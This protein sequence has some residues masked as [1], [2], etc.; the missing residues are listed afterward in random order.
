MKRLG[1]FMEY[2]QLRAN[3]F[4]VM[5]VVMVSLAFGI[6][7]FTYVPIDIM[8]ALMGLMFLIFLLVEIPKLG[9]YATLLLLP[10]FWSPFLDAQLLGISGIKISV[11]LPLIAFLYL[12]F[13][14]KPRKIQGEDQVFFLIFI[15][16]FTVS[17]VRSFSYL[18]VRSISYGEEL[19]ALSHFSTNYLRP[20]LVFLIVII[21][22]AYIRSEKDIKQVTKVILGS[23]VIAIALMIYSVSDASFSDFEIVRT[24]IQENCGMHPGYFANYFLC[25]IPLTLLL[26]IKMKWK[27]CY[28][29]LGIEIVG[30]ALTFSRASYGVAIVSIVI[31]LLICKKVK[32]IVAIVVASP[33][34]YLLIPNMIIQR[35]LSGIAENNVSIISAGRVD[36]IWKPLLQE[37]S[38]NSKFLLFG[39]GRYGIY[40]T[41]SYQ[42]GASLSVN[43]AHNIFLD[44][45][46]D[47]GIIALIFFVIFFVHYLKKFY[48]VAKLTINPLYQSIL[49]GSFLGILGFIVKGTTDGVFWPESSN[50]IIY[51]LLGIAI[52]VV[53]R[54]N[55]KLNY[56]ARV[57]KEEE[58]EENNTVRGLTP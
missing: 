56:V 9:L 16:V 35:A 22:A 2:S 37:L 32:A 51:V 6:C 13:V 54:Y 21:L 31:T 1:D 33:I 17:I 55:E 20:L 57:T 27:L 24:K 52:A 25:L 29:L 7:S 26:A 53:Y 41:T 49:Y 50:A 38:T 43:N 3:P 44:I 48:K 8:F 23:S 14:I 34:F 46:C 12:I 10:V 19:T 4:L 58:L 15:G 42:S 36:S 47:G 5:I 18:K 11:V 45:V 30:V 39:N 28:L 40:H